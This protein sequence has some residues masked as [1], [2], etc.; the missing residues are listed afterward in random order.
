MWEN[1][2]IGLLLLAIVIA[3]FFIAP[4]IP[5]FTQAFAKPQINVDYATAVKGRITGSSVSRQYYR[6]YLDGNTEQY[7]DFNAFT[8]PLTPAE[9]QMNEDEQHMLGLGQQ[10]K[11]GDIVSK[12]AKSTLLTVQ[13]GDSI[14]RWFCSTP[15]E[16]EQAQKDAR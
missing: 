16:I 4:H 3:F 8:R 15:E 9:E 13:R 6:Y 14:S 1:I 11:T 10:L 7:Y 5:H 2:K 12:A